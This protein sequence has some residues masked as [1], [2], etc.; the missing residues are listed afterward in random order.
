VIGSGKRGI[1]QSKSRNGE[2]TV[3]AGRD[4]RIGGRCR[5]K[6]PGR[7]QAEEYSEKALE[8]GPC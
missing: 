8:W 1:G 3:L 6:G 5:V 7:F 4:H 2:G